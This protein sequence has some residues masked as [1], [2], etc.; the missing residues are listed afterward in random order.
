MAG[1]SESGVPKRTLTA[2]F[3]LE[4]GA[5]QLLLALWDL[6]LGLSP[7]TSSPP[8]WDCHNPSQCYTLAKG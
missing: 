5:D 3:P 2:V 7:S 6:D 8:S 4:A 1:T